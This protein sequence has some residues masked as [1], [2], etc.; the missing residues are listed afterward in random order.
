M[1]KQ[2]VHA[3]TMCTSFITH[4]LVFI[5]EE[6]AYFRPG[7]QMFLSLFVFTVEPSLDF[8]VSI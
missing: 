6:C 8:T 3:K 1:Y 7:V 4:K 5:K 2:C